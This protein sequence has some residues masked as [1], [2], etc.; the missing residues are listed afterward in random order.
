[1]RQQ[2][3]ATA[4]IA[5][6]PA[7]GR[8]VR[9]AEFARPG[10]SDE[11]ETGQTVCYMDELASF[12][13]GERSVVNATHCALAEAGI[14]PDARPIDIARAI[15]WWLKRTIRYVPTPATSALV[16]QTLIAPSALL[17]MRDP[18]GDCPQFSMLASAMFRNCC[19]PCFF[20]TIAAEPSLPDIYSHVYN[21]VEVAPGELMPFDSS[22]GPAPGAE[23]ARPLKARVWPTATPSCSRKGKLIMLRSSAHPSG[24]RNS[25]TRR[26]G[27]IT[28]DADGNCYDADTGDYTTPTP[29]APIAPSPAQV[30]AE[31]YPSILA[32]QA[33]ATAAMNPSTFPVGSSPTTGGSSLFTT[34]ANDLTTLAAPLTKALAAST[35][36]PYYITG[37]NGQQVLYNPAT[38]TTVSGL[39]ASFSSNPT[40]WLLGGLAVVVLIAK[41]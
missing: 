14:G 37:P 25:H 33:A 3:P 9:T 34:L 5:F 29:I 13:A 30:N 4:A 11:I 15:F 27:Q 1:L 35:A 22:N 36:K 26:L 2:S 16:D 7:Y 23:Y 31:L 8:S 18:E 32:D 19:I 24:Y 10:A 40:L 6:D 17:A 39:A 21:V 41:K 28:C 12:D 38:G 20:K